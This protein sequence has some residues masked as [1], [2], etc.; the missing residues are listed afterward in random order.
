MRKVTPLQAERRMIYPRLC[1]VAEIDI[2]KVDALER[3]LAAGGSI[4]PVVVAMYGESAMPIDGHHRL[5]AAARLRMN[6]DAWIVSGRAFDALDCRL[7]DRGDDT[8]AE[9]HIMCGN[10][11][12]MAVAGNNGDDRCIG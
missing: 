8:R 10:V 4:P 3:H 1:A 7:R 11:P 2:A 12:A 6:I 5:M 9:D